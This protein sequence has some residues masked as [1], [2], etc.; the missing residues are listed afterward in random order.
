MR[1]RAESGGFGSGRLFACGLGLDDV[2]TF[3]D[4]GTKRPGEVEWAT[5]FVDIASGSAKRPSALPLRLA[6]RGNARGTMSMDAFSREGL[7]SLL[8][9]GLEP[10]RRRLEPRR[11]YR[12]APQ[13]VGDREDDL[14]VLTLQTPNLRAWSPSVRTRTASGR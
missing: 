10:V 4:A 8:G 3:C 12:K 14:T 1:F 7:L 13:V 9:A 6:I 11:E 5:G 2:L